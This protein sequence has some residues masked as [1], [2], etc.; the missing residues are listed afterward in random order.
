MRTSPE[1]RANKRA[2]REARSK[3]KKSGSQVCG[4]LHDGVPVYFTVPK[5]ASDAQIADA[6]FAAVNGRPRNDTERML[7]HMAEAQAK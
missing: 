7:G 3:A 4:V 1:V 6:A 5:D 2:F